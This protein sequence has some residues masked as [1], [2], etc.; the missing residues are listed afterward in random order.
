M[1]RFTPNTPMSSGADELLKHYGMDA[2]D[3]RDSALGDPETDSRNAFNI[4]D[5]YNMGTAPTKSGYIRRFVGN[6]MEF[7]EG[8]YT[9]SVVGNK[10]TGAG[11]DSNVLIFGDLNM[12]TSD[13]I[14]INANHIKFVNSSEGEIRFY[15]NNWEKGFYDFAGLR[16]GLSVDMHVVL[17][18][19]TIHWGAAMYISSQVIGDTRTISPVAFQSSNASTL[20]LMLVGCNLSQC[21]EAVFIL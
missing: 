1:A 8:P 2:N 9:E 17:T 11:G 5:Y 14:Y 19:S 7:F 10:Y 3:D 18:L 21:V 13:D 4:A 20:G 6:R 16:T 12:V 15:L